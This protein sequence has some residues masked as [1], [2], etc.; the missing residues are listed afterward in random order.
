MITVPP[1][2]IM[3]PPMAWAE[4]I[5]PPNKSVIPKRKVLFFIVFLE[6]W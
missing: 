4:A 1:H 6:R 2:P 3:Q 5:V